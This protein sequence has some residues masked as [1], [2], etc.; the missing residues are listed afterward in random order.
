MKKIIKYTLRGI[1]ITLGLLILIYTAAYIYLSVNKKEL[2]AD[3]RKQVSEKF[4]GDIQ[5]GNIELSFID[6]FPSIA[7][8]IENISIK[9]SQFAQHGHPLFTA[10]KVYSAIS[11]L[12]LL[13][14]NNP[15]SR[16]EID[17]AQLYIYTDTSGYTN[18]Y[19]F[20]PKSADTTKTESKA[21][22]EI[23][24]ITFKNV[25]LVMNNQLK[26]KLFDLNI[27][28]LY[29][30]M[31]NT[32]SSITIKTDND[33]L[34]HDLAFNVQVGSYL[35]E[36]TLNGDID[37]VY[38]KK[39]QQLSF[40]GKSVNIRDHPFDISGAFTFTDTPFYYF[41]VASKNI[42]YDFAKNLLTKKLAKT[43]SIVKLEAN[44][45]NVSSYIA[46]PL[47]GGEPSINIQW[48]CSPNNI[49]SPI[50]DF[51]DCSFAGSFTNELKK[52]EPRCD[53]NSRISIDHFSGLYEGIRVVSKQVFISNLTFPVI[54]CDVK[55]DFDLSQ[56]NALLS[57]NV[58]ELKE[59]K[60]SLDIQYNGPIENNNRNNTTINGLL[61]ISNGQLYYL[62][63][64]IPMNDANCTIAFKNTDVYV[65]NFSSSVK[66]N[67]LIINGVGK[68]LLAFMGT[69]TSK[70]NINWSVYSPSINLNNFNSLLQ[71][72]LETARRKTTVSKLGNTAAEFDQI[73]QQANFN[74]TVKAGE[75]LYKK[76][77]ATNV[78]ASLGL[79]DEDWN[80]SQISMQHGGG[81][82][83]I[84]GT[85][86]QK[87]TRY[88]SSNLQVSMDNVDINKV[89]YAFDNFGQPGIS[90]TNLNGK[91]SA[92]ANIVMDIDRDM[93]QRPENMV[94]TI[95]FSLKN[96]A[97]LHYEPMKKIQSIIF[98]KRNFDEIHF[99][100]LKD[101]LEINNGE[102][103]INR[104]EIQSTALTMFVEGLYSQQGKT[105]IS[106]QVPLKNL[107][108]R[109]E[110]YI[111]EN[112][113][114]DSKGGT[115]IYIRGQTGKDGSVQFK[116]DVFKKFRKG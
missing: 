4:S 43:L 61:K 25:R 49:V 50:A 28:S 76:F 27:S 17:D 65:N 7:V 94:G 102:V 86:N 6:Q 67:K 20:K 46:G 56:I 51:K 26:R 116:L 93:Q 47:N 30:E 36:A 99:A 3:V 41:K 11:I 77:K 16:I 42:G 91:L 23:E 101:L 18:T 84:N 54:D 111:P 73:V 40:Q 103:K 96:G 87:N 66:G 81:S 68:N 39:L 13:Q 29:C 82:M 55:S 74:I 53:E 92:K 85:L 106:I 9:D 34:V 60:G 52:A 63:T 113:G 33:I 83:F 10:K 109:D 37:L 114:A 108:K 110:D 45:D 70:A 62:P 59:G 15:L 22:T 98:K 38:Q 44:L 105:D 79:H 75:L 5:I 14:K 58:F 115:S 104:M 112:K 19:L 35:K 48:K 97:L 71:K 57:S 24:K 2:L 69:N 78:T 31:A 32:D 95:D 107:K 8:L 12:R 89:M 80:L 1:L 72:R 88:Y 100:E 64:K 90:Y 21:K